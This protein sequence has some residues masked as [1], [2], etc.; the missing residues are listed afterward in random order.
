MKTTIF[1][2][3][4]L[5]YNRHAA[6]RETRPISDWKITLRQ[7]FLDLLKSKSTASLLD[8]GA[9]TGRDSLFFGQNRLDV[10]SVDLSFEMCVLNRQKDVA[11]AQ[12][13]LCEFAFKPE[14]FGAIWSLNCLLHVPKNEMPG[15]LAQIREILMPDGLF[16][17][18]IYGGK[19]SEGVWLD[20][21]YRPQ[22]FFSF[23]TDSEIQVL[24]QKYFRLLDF[25][26][27]DVGLKALHFQSMLLQK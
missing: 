24:V 2:N 27:L 19:N 14:S 7:Q 17:L 15:I 22:R 12:M 9:G 8:L 5:S 3:L 20:D 18:G 16:F 23:Y 26:A 1:S 6:E 25:H 4:I 10:V 11:V 21:H 13:N